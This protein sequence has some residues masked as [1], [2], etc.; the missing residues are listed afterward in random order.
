MHLYDLFAFAFAGF[1]AATFCVKAEVF[2][3]EPADLGKLLF[4]KKFADVVVGFDVG[5]RV[6][7]TAFPN[8]ALVDELHSSHFFLQ[9][10]PQQL[11]VEKR[12]QFVWFLDGDENLKP[13]VHFNERHIVLRVAD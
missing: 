2:G 13:A 12:Q 5:D 9:V 11:V 1:A 6:R 4:G 10:R 3:L 7:A 8:W